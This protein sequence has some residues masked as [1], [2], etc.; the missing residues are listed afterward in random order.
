MNLDHLLRRK[1]LLRSEL[2]NKLID[3]SF[4]R[5]ELLKL[6]LKRV[7]F[8]FN[9]L[10]YRRWNTNYYFKER[11]DDVGNCLLYLQR[12]YLKVK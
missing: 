1:A 12:D 4:T 11:I 9:K 3:K 2:L 8:K 6:G 10:I 7:G 5:Q